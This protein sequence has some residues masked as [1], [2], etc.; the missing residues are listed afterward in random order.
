[1]RTHQAG[2]PVDTIVG[3]PATLHVMNAL[4]VLANRHGCD[5]AEITDALDFARSQGLV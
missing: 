3:D 1:V 2:A 4:D 5:I